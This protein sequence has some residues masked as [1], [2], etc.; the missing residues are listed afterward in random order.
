M[1]IIKLM[2]SVVCSVFIWLAH[3]HAGIEATGKA[4]PTWGDSAT[5]IVEEA[6]RPEG[7]GCNVTYQ[8]D[9]TT[10]IWQFLICC[11][12]QIAPLW[13]TAIGSLLLMSYVL[14]HCVCYVSVCSVCYVSFFTLCSVRILVCGL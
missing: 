1:Y 12:V 6:L 11:L 5:R 4:R 8:R 7:D 13:H 2:H 3:V 9:I 14:V 10:T